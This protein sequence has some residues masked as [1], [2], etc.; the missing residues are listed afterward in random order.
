M[1]VLSVICARKGSKGFKNKCGARIVDK[2]VVEYSMQYSLSLGKNVKTVVSTD[3]EELI[4]YCKQN[5]IAYI[6]RNP[7]MC[8]D[9]SKI[10][11]ALADAIEKEGKGYEYCS[12]VYGNIPTRY[13]EIFKKASEFLHTHKDYDG[14]ISMQNVEKFNPEAMYDYNEETL[15]FEEKSSYRRQ[16]NPQKMIHDGHT[17]IFKSQK[18]Y[19]RFKN[20]ES[21]NTK[22]LYSVYGDKF[23]PIINNEVVIEIDTEKDFKLTKAF[24]CYK[25]NKA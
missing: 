19:K 1:K 23:K 24:I 2:M 21:Y 9:D 3:I 25:N 22:C 13:P 18:F 16:T 4:D 11:D 20:G 14:A 6:K 7:I 8:M 12:L 17:F 15:P 5:N 10:D